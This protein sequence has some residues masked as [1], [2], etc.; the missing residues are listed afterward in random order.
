MIVTSRT[1]RG[2]VVAT[3][4]AVAAVPVGAVVVVAADPPSSPHED[5]NSA[6]M[7]PTATKIFERLPIIGTSPGFWDAADLGADLPVRI[8]PSH[9]W[10]RY[11]HLEVAELLLCEAIC[12]E[13]A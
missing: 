5:A 10:R 9:S 2:A 6:T 11:L 13:A 7:N 4:V 1:G 8:V 12:V 3:L